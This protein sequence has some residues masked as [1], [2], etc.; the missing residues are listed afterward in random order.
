MGTG[1]CAVRAIPRPSS[2]GAETTRGQPSRSSTTA[3]PQTST[4]ESTAPTSWKC[5]SSIGMP[6]TFASARPIRSN[7]ARAA[8][9]ARG[10]SPL[11]STIARI[12]AR[13]RAGGSAPSTTTSTWVPR[14]A[15]WL[16]LET[17]SRQPGTPRERSASSRRLR[18]TPRSSAAARNMSPAM[19]P[20]GFEDE[21]RLHG[22]A[23]CSWLPRAC[24][25]VTTSAVVMAARPEPVE[26]RAERVYS[27]AMSPATNAAPKPLSMFTTVTLGAHE[28]SIVRSG[29]MPASDAP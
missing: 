2:G 8:A 14:I 19:P 18:S 28:L 1:P 21:Q 9:F 17:S 6:W 5:T 7:S 22:T 12:S 13:E 15:D 26:G 10:A 23:P 3:A 11:A 29:A 25:G 16:R 4:I 27:R 20:M 24:R